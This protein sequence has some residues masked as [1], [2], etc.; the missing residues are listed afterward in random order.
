MPATQA[1]TIAQRREMMLL[2]EEGYTNAAVA[3][4]MGISSWTA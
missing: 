2:V 1:T 3:E 4:Q